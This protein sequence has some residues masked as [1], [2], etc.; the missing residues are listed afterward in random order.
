[1]DSSRFS[2][3]LSLTRRRFLTAGLAG[4]A[5][6]ALYSGEIARHVIQI[7]HPEIRLPNLPEAFDGFHIVQLSDIHLNEFTEPFFLRESVDR[8]NRL[9][10]DAV[11]LTGDFVTSELLPRKWSIPSAWKCASILEGL[12]CRQRYA[13]LGNHDVLIGAQPVTE[14]LTA[15]NITVLRNACVAL[16]RDS[17]R[18][19]LSGLD[20]P[21]EGHPDP[22]R[23]VPAFIRQRPNEPVL[24]MCHAPDFADR[25]LNHPA[26]SAVQLMLS[27]HTHGGQVRLPFVGPMNLPEWGR[28]YVEGIFRLRGLQLYV[29]RGIGTVG[30]PFRLNCPPEITSIT[31]R[32]G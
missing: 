27:G 28:K 20:D 26:G 29:N 19:W 1:V 5:G 21:V 11:F 15:S 13:V 25:L 18:L 3:T 2:S 10:P 9:R 4:A 23:A 7:S 32:R 17:A 16:Q 12:Q 8:I 22:D 6:L 30:L 24:L 14:A 31:L